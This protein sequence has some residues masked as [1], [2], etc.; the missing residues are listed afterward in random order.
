VTA[1]PFLDLTRETV[2]FRDR[3]D[4]AIDRVLGSG[5]FVLGPEVEAFETLFA[6][7]CGRPYA[8]GVASGTDAIAI[9]LRAAGVEPG[10][11]VIAP[12]NTCVPTIA[13][14]EQAGAVP[15]LADAESTTYGLDPTSFEHAISDR[16]RAVVVVHLYGKVGDWDAIA[17]IARARGL[18][19][20]ED[21]AQAHGA[22]HGGK[23]AGCLGD[24]AAFS[25]YPTKNL[26]ALG[27][28]GAVVTGDSAIAE[29]ARR[30]R[31]Y[32]EQRRYESVET[33]WNSRL[34][35]LQAAVLQEKLTWLDARN[36]RRATLARRY[37][38]ALDGLPGLVLPGSDDSDAHHLFVIQVENRAP[39]RA[40]LAER[41]IGT[42]VHYPIPIHRHPA[43]ERLGR[44]R[45]PL[46]VSE[47]L[48]DRVL[49][50]PLYPELDESEVDA[51]VLGLREELNG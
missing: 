31:T 42:L 39:L 30:L 12:A 11:E 51:V 8:V 20:V 37:R 50:L 5:V 44:T 41:G 47:R 16:T 10:D 15:V 28:A 23:R 43:Y 33:G 38:A 45:V 26:G 6:R 7:Y 14:I 29:R 19:L 9:A 13:G 18:I 3:I 17:A 36:A 34:D 24:V 2:A 32:G 49:S 1:V 40:R 48:S 22:S 27:D 21:A 4:A 46:D 35:P 25:F